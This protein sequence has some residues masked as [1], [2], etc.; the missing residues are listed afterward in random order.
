MANPGVNGWFNPATFSAPAPFTLGNVGRNSM[1][2][3][4]FWNFDM[5]FMKNLRFLERYDVQFR[6]E[7][8]NIFNHPNP[9]GPGANLSVPSTFGKTT[10]FSAA[11][12]I[13]FGLKFAF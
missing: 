8:F 11:R 10:T 3:P 2:A 5:G 9:G 13:L 7:F 1:W 4:G 6:A 12:V